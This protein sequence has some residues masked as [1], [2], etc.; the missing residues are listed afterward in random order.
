MQPDPE[1]SEK[2]HHQGIGTGPHNQ[3][4][5]GRC[6]PS[7]TGTEQQTLGPSHVEAAINVNC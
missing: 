7:Q 5:P 3:H 2:Q 4:K 1:T 6:Q